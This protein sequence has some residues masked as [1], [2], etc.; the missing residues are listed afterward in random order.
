M[1]TITMDATGV[2]SSGKM[3][4]ADRADTQ[5]PAPAF[6]ETANSV[7]FVRSGPH[8][9]PRAATCSS[10]AGPD[11]VCMALYAAFNAH[12][13]SEIVTPLLAGQGGVGAVVLENLARHALAYGDTVKEGGASHDR[14]AILL[15]DF[16]LFRN[17]MLCLR[18]S[19]LQNWFT[20]VVGSPL[21]LAVSDVDALCGV[22]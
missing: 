7:M 3:P 2:I 6:H 8:E 9:N 14:T 12:P 17:E 1:T 5:N 13:V 16:N 20:Q 11:Y 15:S 4:V 22:L 19:V 18:V 21:S 10:S